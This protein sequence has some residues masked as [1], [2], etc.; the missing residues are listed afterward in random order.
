MRVANSFVLQAHPAR[1]L[2]TRRRRSPEHRIA[3]LHTPAASRP[4]GQ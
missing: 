1:F 4:F 2:V 3:E